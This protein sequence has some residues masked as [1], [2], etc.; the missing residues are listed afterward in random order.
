MSAIMVTEDYVNF[1]VAKRLKEKGFD[2]KPFHQYYVSSCGKVFGCKG[3]EMKQTTTN[4]GYKRITL[5]INGKEERWSVHRLVALLFVPNREQK[6]QV[7][8]I[9]GNKENNAASN[10][11]WCTASENNKHAFRTGLKK[12]LVEG[13]YGKDHIAS[14]PIVCVETGRVYNCQR[15]V[16][17]E[18][19]EDYKWTSHLSRACKYGLLDHGFHWRYYEPNELVRLLFEKG[20]TK[21]PLSYDGDYWFCYIQMAMKWLKEV[22]HIFISISF[23]YDKFYQPYYFYKIANVGKKEDWNIEKS[24]HI[25]VEE[26]CEAAIKYCLENLI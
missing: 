18:L 24:E 6:P 3:N 12:N 19:G 21:Y 5:S 17:E 20:Y 23:Q 14:K 9:D 16:A 15:E 22:H 7:N 2:V 8:H 11:E 10:L 26:A 4:R 13:K 25:T 1:E